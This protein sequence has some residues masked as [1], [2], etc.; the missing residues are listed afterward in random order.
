VLLMVQPNAGMAA[1]VQQLVGVPV[2]EV[3]QGRVVRFRLDPQVWAQLSRQADYLPGVWGE[4]LAPGDPGPSRIARPA[5]DPVTAA[6]RTE[7]TL[8][9]AAVAARAQ[10]SACAD[11]LREGRQA[12]AT[13]GL[14]CPTVAELAA[15]RKTLVDRQAR[16]QRVV[17]PEVDHYAYLTEQT[18]VTVLV[19]AP[20]MTPRDLARV[21]GVK[22]SAAAGG[23]LRVVLP[24]EHSLPRVM[25]LS[26]LDGVRRIVLDPAATAPVDDV[27]VASVTVVDGSR[28]PPPAGC[29]PN[30]R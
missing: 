20:G 18:T 9:R 12:R 23:A 6:A 5:V 14:S 13:H 19:T 3:Y 28:L 1:R 4:I 11:K 25:D 30:G 22:A 24:T 10:R 26:Q 17:D 15:R 8:R 29:P 21:R 27:Q 7:M 2:Q 16:Y